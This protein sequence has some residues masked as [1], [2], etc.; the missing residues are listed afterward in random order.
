LN[1]LYT[2]FGQIVSGQEVVERIEQ[3][4]KIVRVTV[5]E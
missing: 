4:D 3:G 1:A 5:T 2:V